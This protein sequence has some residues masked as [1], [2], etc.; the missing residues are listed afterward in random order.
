MRGRGHGKWER[1]E[2]V[3]RCVSKFVVMF[4]CMGL[5]GAAEFY[6]APDGADENPGTKEAPFRSLVK[7]RNAV[8]AVNDAMSEDI[9][10]YLR[11]GVH[12]LRRTLVLTAL[13]SGRN[14]HAVVYKALPGETPVIS[15]ALRVAG[16]KPDAAGRWKAQTRAAEFRQLYV[17]GKRAV[18]ARGACPEGVTRFGDL[19]FIDGDAGYVFP[20]GAMADW[21]NPG[22]IELGEYSSW[23]HMVLKVAGIARDA[24]GHAQVHMLDPW[25]FLAS[26]KEGRQANLPSYI[27]NAF[28]LLDEPG[29]WYLD[30]PAGVIYYLPR[31]GEDLSTSVVTV[32]VVEQLVRLEG[33]VDQPVRNVRFEGIVFADATWLRPSRVGH[34]DVQ[35]NFIIE[36]TNLYARDGFLV[37]V[38]NEYIKSPAHVVLHAAIGCAF[39]R[40]T[41][42][43]LGGAALD[44]ECGAQD[45][46][47]QG[48]RFYDVSGSAVQVGDVL[49]PDHHP[50][51]ARLIVKNN[52]VI[53]NYIH[54]V[55]VEFQ[56]SVGVFAGYTEGTVIAHNEIAQ[57]PYSGISDGWGWG[58]EDSGA[59]NYATPYKYEQPSS[60]KNNRI[61]HNHIHHVMLERDDGGGIYTLSNQP[62]TAIQ[63]NHIHDNGPGGPGGIY[64]DEGSGFIEIT[65]NAVYGVS[66][67]MNYNNRAQDRIRTCQEHDNFFDVAP[68]AAGFPKDVADQ[69]GLEPA[70]RDLLE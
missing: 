68:D 20:D 33:T 6:V 55:G 36:P 69:A 62:G 23:S 41:F 63:G 16:W 38:H 22:D 58:E 43:R 26:H 4:L 37:N 9:V 45:N 65:G 24:E 27:E 31:E 18:R 35:A 5:A 60:A 64:L 11:D 3:M 42:T 39:E 47:I 15:G 54:N 30:R 34:P 44:L 25:F 57:L 28:E 52:R 1:K 40:C 51:D 19:E 49:A 32:P 48:C 14:G 66:T 59:G 46:V 2:C 13:D 29:E 8:R 7:A 53:N 61:E 70:Y 10:V 12:A 56:D 17:N 67:P 50:G 21:R